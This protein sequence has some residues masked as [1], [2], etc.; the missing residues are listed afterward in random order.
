M[1]SE[2]S[3][4]DWREL[5]GMADKQGVSAI[6][7]DGL[8]ALVAAYGKERVAPRLDMGDWQLFIYDWIGVMTQVENRNK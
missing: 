1:F 2:L 7:F 8:Q 6:A 3:L 5:K 4:K